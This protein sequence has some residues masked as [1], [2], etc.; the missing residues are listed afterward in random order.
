MAGKEAPLE[1]AAWELLGCQPA[2]GEANKSVLEQYNQ[3]A[4]ARPKQP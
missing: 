2:Q 1:T 3:E 4:P